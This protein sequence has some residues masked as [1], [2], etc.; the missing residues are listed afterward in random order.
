MI[1]LQT[2]PSSKERYSF[3]FL[4][5]FYFL[6]FVES[7]HQ[8]TMS[9]VIGYPPS[10]IIFQK[11]SNSLSSMLIH[12]YVDVRIFYKRNKNI[13]KFG[14]NLEFC[15]VMYLDRINFLEKTLSSNLELS[16]CLIN[17]MI[18]FV[19]IAPLYLEDTIIFKRLNFHSFQRRI[20]TLVSI[21]RTYLCFLFKESQDRRML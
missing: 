17:L 10:G 11:W 2:F 13:C 9:L 15:T 14:S 7:Y 12:K 6:D 20:S 1:G 21:C 5:L 18:I 3:F 19:K 8:I 4:L 16:F